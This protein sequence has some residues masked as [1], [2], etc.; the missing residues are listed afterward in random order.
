MSTLT[1]GHPVLGMGL[2]ADTGEII[3]FV[4]FTLPASQANKIRTVHILTS[5]RGI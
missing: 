5:V 1:R 2:K 3:Y 4:I